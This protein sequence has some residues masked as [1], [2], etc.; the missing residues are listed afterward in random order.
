MARDGVVIG[1]AY[2]GELAEGPHAEYTLLE[3]KL[4][5]ETLARA[6]LFT[7]LEPCTSRNPP[8][9]PCAE[10]IIARQIGKVFIGTLDPNPIIG[11][12]GYFQLLEAGIQIALFDPA[13]VPRIE[14]MNR[15]FF[16][17]YRSTPTTDQI[18]ESVKQAPALKIEGIGWSQSVVGGTQQGHQWAWIINVTLTNDS[19]VDPIG[20]SRVLLEIERDGSHMPLLQVDDAIRSSEIFYGVPR[21]GND[22]GKNPYLRPRESLLG[23]FTFVDFV[24]PFSGFQSALLTLVDTAG[25]THEFPHPPSR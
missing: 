21:S 6:T 19:T 20:I 15:D 10:R 23:T 7:T 18:I 11:S 8:K 14:E 4:S 3:Q 22:L 5:D 1:K 12:K 17:Q 24:N 25:N 2:R 13:L 9:I 16:R